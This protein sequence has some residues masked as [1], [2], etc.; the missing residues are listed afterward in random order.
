MPF[1]CF[2]CTERWIPIHIVIGMLFVVSYANLSGGLVGDFW[3]WTSGCERSLRRPISQ[4]PC[5][6]WC[7]LCVL[8]EWGPNVLPQY[9]H[10]LNA[11]LHNNI[12]P[13]PCGIKNTVSF[14]FSLFFFFSFCFVFCFVLLIREEQWNNLDLTQIKSRQYLSR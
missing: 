1:F 4:N 6:V 14:L 11:T 8:W 5:F 9:P 13:F 12:A 3:W 10:H 7:R 2:L